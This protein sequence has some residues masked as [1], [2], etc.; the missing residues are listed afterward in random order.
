MRLGIVRAVLAVLL[1]ACTGLTLPRLSFRCFNCL[2]LFLM[3]RDMFR[4]PVKPGSHVQE[5]QLPLA[6]SSLWGQ[7]SAGVSTEL[8]GS[9]QLPSSI[10]LYWGTYPT[11]LSPFCMY[12]K[13]LS[14]SGSENTLWRLKFNLPC[15]PFIY[16]ACTVVDVVWPTASPFRK[17]A[18][19][20]GFL[21]KL[22]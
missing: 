13:G 7:P 14:S 22:C 21:K 1:S 10:M 12:E 5:K 4:L 17:S 8:K 2:W 9:L 3:G 6:P 11:F 16:S 15:L 20:L 18:R 19:L